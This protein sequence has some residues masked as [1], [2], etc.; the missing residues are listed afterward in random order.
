MESLPENE[1]SCQ[2]N[3]VSTSNAALESDAPSEN[4]DP[5]MSAVSD[6]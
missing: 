3:V 4:E 1:K 5:S 6:G 2:E